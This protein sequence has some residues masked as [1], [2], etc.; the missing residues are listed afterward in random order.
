MMDIKRNGT[1]PSARGPASWF[2]GT[3]RIDTP[4]SATA[5]GRAGVA[6][7]TFEPGARTVWHTHPLGQMLIVTA[8]LGLRS[9][10][11]ARSRRFAPAI[12]SG[13]HPAKSTG[14]GHRQRWP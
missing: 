1:S 9:V 6:I 14:T 13:S 12:R 3:V 5:P 10:R 7:V 4:F 2:T 8:A 11:A